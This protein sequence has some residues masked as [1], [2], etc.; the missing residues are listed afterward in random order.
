M[1]ESQ[2][3]IH[4][5][6]NQHGRDHSLRVTWTS[7]DR[8]DMDDETATWRGHTTMPQFDRPIDQAWVALLRMMQ[9]LESQGALGRV[10][11]YY[12]ESIEASEI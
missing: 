6:V 2:W 4:A 9:L 1:S 5:N 8:Y 7:Y 10:S 3:T 12:Q 11:G